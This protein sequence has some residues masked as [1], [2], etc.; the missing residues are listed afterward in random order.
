MADK[1]VLHNGVEV[2]EGWPESIKAAQEI[3]TYLIG[4]KHYARVRYGDEKEDWG[5]NKQPC[6]DC[7]VSK[8]QFHVAGCDVE[9]CPAC[10]R[11]VITCGCVYDDDEVDESR[12]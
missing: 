4:G 8:G 10:G 7:A 3:T 9:R 5:A 6:H 2:L 12:R 11:Q 1:F